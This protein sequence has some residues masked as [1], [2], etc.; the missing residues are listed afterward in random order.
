M[1][2]SDSD[3]NPDTIFGVKTGCEN[4]GPQRVLVVDDDLITLELA[5]GVLESADFTVSV[6][7]SGVQALSLF[8]TEMPDLILLDVEMPELDGFGVCQRLRALSAGKNTPIIMMTGRGD[9][10]AVERAFEVEATDFVNK[11]VNWAA[12]VQRIRYILRAAATFTELQRSQQ[13]LLNAQKM[14]GL[15]YW[16]WDMTTDLLYMSEQSCELLG[17]SAQVLSKLG[18][19]IDIVYGEDRKQFLSE[20][21]DKVSKG[22]PW[23]FEHRVVTADGDIRWI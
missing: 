10:L 16:D 9:D 1:S 5:R 4:L 14:A 11:P 8:E 22:E 3:T 6:A 23:L 7:D 18:D 17:H 20:L 2:D 12:L 21:N 15:G 13:R 19:Y